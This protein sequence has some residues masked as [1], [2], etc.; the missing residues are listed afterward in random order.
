MEDEGCECRPLGFLLGL[1]FAVLALIL[2]LVGAVIWVLGYVWFL[3][4]FQSFFGLFSYS[5]F[6]FLLFFSSVFSI[7]KLMNCGDGWELITQVYIEL[8][9]PMLHLLCRIGQFGCDSCKASSSD[10]SVLHSQ[11]SLL[12]DWNLPLPPPSLSS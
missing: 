11:N 12:E 10:S 9:V 1:P 5:G 6:V 8:L 3:S 4:N 7:W 2:S